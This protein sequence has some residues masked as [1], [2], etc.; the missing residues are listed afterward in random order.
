MNESILSVVKLGVDRLKTE[1]KLALGISQKPLAMLVIF[2]LETIFRTAYQYY[3]CTR[4]FFISDLL[5]AHYYITLHRPVA[6]SLSLSPPQPG[7]APAERD[8]RHR[9][10][11]RSYSVT[12]QPIAT[13]LRVFRFFVINGSPG[14][15]IPRALLKRFSLNLKLQIS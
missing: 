14:E 5:S 10:K 13:D 8:A 11:F 1:L 4:N 3:S 2:G 7:R 9:I 12:L 6:P 15:S